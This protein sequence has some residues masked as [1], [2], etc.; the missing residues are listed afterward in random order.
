[1]TAVQV[2]NHHP[3]KAKAVIRKLVQRLAHG[4]QELGAHTALVLSHAAAV[5]KLVHAL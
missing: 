4:Q 1:M 2:L 3:A 5:L